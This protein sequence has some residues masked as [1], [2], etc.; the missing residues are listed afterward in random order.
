MITLRSSIA[1]C[2]FCLWALLILAL[3]TLGGPAAAQPG[4]AQAARL[5]ITFISAPDQAD[6]GARY[7]QA[8]ALGAGWN[9]W[10]LYWDRV[11][12]GPGV[13]DW[14]A[15][16]RLV[17][18]DLRY[19]L[20]TNV[21]LLGRPG[22]HDRGGSIE[23][24]YSAA[25]SDGTDAPGAGKLPNPANPWAL[26]VHQAV[27]RYK[28]GGLLAASNRWPGGWGITTW[29]AWNEPDLRMF[30]S[31]SVEDYARLLKVTYLVAK[32]ADPGAQIV[33]GGLAYGNP[34]QDDW[35]AKVLAIYAGDPQREAFNWYHDIVALH[36]YSN[37]RRTGLIVSR[38]RETLA[39]AGLTRRIWVNETGVPV[40]DDYPGP[41]WTAAD[42]AGRILRATMQQQAAFVIQS[43]VYAWAAGADVVMF[44]QLYDDC[45]NQPGGTNFPP[46]NG[47]LCLNGALC[48][49][50]AH[51]L[52]RNPATAPCFS[53]HPMPGTPRPAAS[54]Y[55]R[56]A[57]TFSAP[58]GEQQVLRDDQTATVISFRRLRTDE[59]IVVLWSRT[60]SESRLEIE[61]LGVGG[62][63]LTPQ[64]E[65]IM[66]TPQ[67][68]RYSLALP[69]ATRD[70]YPFLPSGQ[71]AAIGGPPLILVEQG[72]RSSSNPALP[73][74]GESS[75][76]AQ[77][78]LPTPGGPASTPVL[79]PTTDPAQDSAPPVTRM[80]PLPA[81]SA[82][83][84]TV[85]WSGADDGGIAGYL[86]W[87]RIDD[88]EW[89]PWL[90]T[91]ATEAIYTGEAG[92]RYAFA[93][94]AVDLAGNWSLNTELTPQAETRVEG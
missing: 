35:L 54:A 29:E 72:A 3:L 45:G 84:F 44:H 37:P 36:S 28:P 49:G 46:H 64:N 92:R 40:W 87:V 73:Q 10:P 70:D 61:A 33:F 85:S 32:Q 20:R 76:P 52:F 41:T 82:A 15:Y 83:T 74:F 80:T 78:V 19:G 7:Q 62:A 86:V 9:R 89:Q 47:E 6:N 12:R 56:L 17:S 58:F 21:I 77:P 50:D 11:E 55:L 42:P 69:P 71:A 13:Y 1:R 51:G 75:V 14:T 94:W 65:R 27:M 91:R 93:V 66:I 23:G 16:D 8:L 90:E 30:W 31:A 26:F 59:R 34:D 2:P 88:G 60:L 48:A 22:F 4:T 25:F 57:Q 67:D 43:A 24:L 81:V 5:G 18:D 53:Q 39:R 38:A 79:R 63:V 68:G